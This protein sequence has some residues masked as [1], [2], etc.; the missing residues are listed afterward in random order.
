MDLEQRLLVTSCQLVIRDDKVQVYFPRFEE[1]KLITERSEY[2]QRGTP[3]TGKVILRDQKRDLAAVQVP[4][5]PE[6]ITELRVATSS[7]EQGARLHAI[8]HAGA[9]Q[10]LWGY[11]T[12]FVRQIN[13]RKE[14]IG[15]VAIDAW[16]VVSQLPFNEGD[17]GSP[18]LDDRG[19]VVGMAVTN[20]DK[21]RLVSVGVE[22]REIRQFLVKAK[23]AAQR[24]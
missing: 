9:S 8:G 6:G 3:I 4:M 7:P 18:L 16:V 11:A 22:A 10:G 5:I 12:G 13:Q 17:G 19:E 1:G 14:A 23:T 24:P 20:V 21:T 2:E 15:G